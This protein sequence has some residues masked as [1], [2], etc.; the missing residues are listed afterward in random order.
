[1]KGEKRSM[2]QRNVIRTMKQRKV[3]YKYIDIYFVY[4]KKTPC[5]RV[6]VWVQ[7]RLRRRRRRELYGDQQSINWNGDTN[8]DI[9]N[10][11][12]C[13]CKCMGYGILVVFF[14][15]FF[16]KVS[17]EN[18]RHTPQNGTESAKKIWHTHKHR[19]REHILNRANISKYTKIVF[20]NI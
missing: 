10:K 1:M 17:R 2:Q 15:F 3:K 7:S 14:F 8:S 5:V 11:Y 20:K 4:E 16:F 13:K 18:D 19:L 6:C 9:G 12:K